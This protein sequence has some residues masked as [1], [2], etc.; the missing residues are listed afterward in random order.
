MVAYT[1]HWAIV[2]HETHCYASSW[3][4]ISNNTK[5]WPQL[6]EK[7]V[8]YAQDMEFLL[9]KISNFKNFYPPKCQ[10][11]PLLDFSAPPKGV[12]TPVHRKFSSPPLKEFCWKFPAPLQPGGRHYA[13]SCPYSVTP[14]PTY[15]SCVTEE[16]DCDFK[17]FFAKLCAIESVQLLQKDLTLDHLAWCIED[18]NF[19]DDFYILLDLPLTKIFD[20]SSVNYWSPYAYHVI[21]YCTMGLIYDCDL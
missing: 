8:A 1:L 7:S 18:L 3:I 11:P 21:P 20:T 2:S 4:M 19:L 13:V 17:T 16:F 6:Y 5:I 12:G 14:P 9:L 10:T 15:F